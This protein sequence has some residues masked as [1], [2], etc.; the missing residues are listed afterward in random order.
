MTSL[1][2]DNN[3]AKFQIRSYQPGE[4]KINDTIYTQ[5]V[6]VSPTQLISDWQ[7]QSIESLSAQSLARLVDLKPDIVLIG[8]GEKMVLIKPDIYG[9]LINRGI[10]VE[11]MDTSA[12][13]RTFNALTSENRD[14]VAALV[15]R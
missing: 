12:A 10:G 6:I 9:E 14:V 3:Q 1:T 4:L 5:S 7:P 15:I 8:T 11:V 13:C 2:L